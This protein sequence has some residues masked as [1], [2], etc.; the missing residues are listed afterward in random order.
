MI[1]FTPMDDLSSLDNNFMYSPKAGGGGEYSRNDRFGFGSSEIMDI[2]MNQYNLILD[3]NTI[4]EKYSDF[5]SPESHLKY[6]LDMYNIKVAYCKTSS[7][8]Y[9]KRT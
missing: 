9:G 8:R 3:Y 4:P 6:I 1:F 2:Y 7:K 5:K